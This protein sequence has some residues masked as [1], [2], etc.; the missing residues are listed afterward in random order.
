MGCAGNDEIKTPDGETGLNYLCTGYK[1]FFN[2]I[3]Q[4][5]HVMAKLLQQKRPPA[6]I[7]ELM[8]ITDAKKL[9][10][11]LAQSGRDDTCL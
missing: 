5:M 10:V 6:D 4:P 11:A 2:H 3:D 8:A 7:M 1:H 9:E